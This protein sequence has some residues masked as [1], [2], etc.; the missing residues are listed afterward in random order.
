M[1]DLYRGIICLVLGLG[2]VGA[3]IPIMLRFKTITLAER[4]QTNKEEVGV[5]SAIVTGVAGMT[6]LAIAITEL[7]SGIA[8]AQDKDAANLS[9]IRSHLEGVIG[10]WAHSEEPAIIAAIERLYNSQPIPTFVGSGKTWSDDD[11]SH[12][13][14]R[15]FI[16]PDQAA[17]TW[18]EAII[19]DYIV[20][21]ALH[22]SVFELI[23]SEGP[24]WTARRTD[25]IRILNLE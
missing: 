18:N 3:F 24:E 22:C 20:R 14:L 12:I 8:Y 17:S 9:R 25:C 19:S 6:L 15:D 10:T 7:P 21:G 13:T 4:Q 1:E 11:V 23:N 16:S 5:V 2:A